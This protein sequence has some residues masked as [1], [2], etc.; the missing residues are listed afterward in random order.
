VSI[1]TAVFH[2][3]DGA[4]DELYLG[5]DGGLHGGPWLGGPL[6]KNGHRGKFCWNVLNPVGFHFNALRS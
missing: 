3:H 4:L 2:I 1:G 6:W 5:S